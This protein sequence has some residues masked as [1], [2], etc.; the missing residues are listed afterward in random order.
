MTKP[1]NSKIKV[2]RLGRV[3]YKHKDSAKAE[4]FLAP[5]GFV[6]V[7]REGKRIYYRGYGSEPFLYCLEES[8]SREIFADVT[9]IYDLDEAPG[10]GKCVTVKDPI[11][12]WPL[13]LVY[14]QTPVEPTKDYRYLDFNFP[15][16]KNRAGN[17][18]QRFEKGPALIHK[19]GHF[20][21]CVTQFQKTFDFYTKNFNFVPSDTWEKLLQ[22]TT[23]FSYLKAPNLMSITPRSR[24]MHDFDVEVLGHDHLRD[25]G[26]QN[27]WGV[28]RHVLGSQ[29]FDYWYDPSSFIVEHYVDGD[30]VNCHSKTNIELATPDGLH[31]W[32]PRLPEG[33]LT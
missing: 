18:F 5:F 6:E 32:G 12:G 25:L 23:A 1:N 7:K 27:C 13:H 19:L 20:G 21:L 14:G 24:S 4:K 26:Y 8:S 29:I 28:G 11:D 16:K 30:Q 2:L 3:Y 15:H 22:T 17:E 9:E 33:F 31:V 10:G